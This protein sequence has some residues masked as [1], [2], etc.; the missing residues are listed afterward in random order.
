M[1]CAFCN[2]D[3]PILCDNYCDVILDKYPVTKGHCLIIPK[4][5]SENFFECTP[6]EIDSINELII[7]VRTYLEDKYSPTGF[8]I[9]MNCGE[10]AGQ[11]IYHTH[12]HVIPR[13]DGDTENSRGGVRGVIPNK[14]SY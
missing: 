13:Y 14:Q 4:R 3:N 6:E 12:I 5:H 2:I 11:T 8:N 1:N 7:K 9:G 10:S